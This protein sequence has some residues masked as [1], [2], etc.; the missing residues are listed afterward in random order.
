MLGNV[1]DQSAEKRLAD[2]ADGNSGAKF[3]VRP[4]A[5]FRYSRKGERVITWSAE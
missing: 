1:I 3:E 4:Q 5:A 2:V